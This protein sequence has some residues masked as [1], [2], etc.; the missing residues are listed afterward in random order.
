MR[1]TGSGERQASQL[2]FWTVFQFVGQ[3]VHRQRLCGGAGSA[4]C[5]F[6]L[7]E[8]EEE[9][10]KK[11]KKWQELQLHRR[12]HPLPDSVAQAIVHLTALVNRAEAGLEQIDR[13]FTLEVLEKQSFWCLKE[14]QM[15][16][17][18]EVKEE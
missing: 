12:P 9:L 15:E 13:T 3:L 17:Q 18:K 16:A 5:Q 14:A 8:L 2:Q 11:E 4:G 10:S 1:E 6:G 7:Q